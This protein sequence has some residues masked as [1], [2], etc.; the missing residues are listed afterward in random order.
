MRVE[1]AVLGSPSLTVLAVS[2]DVSQA[3]LYVSSELMSF[4]NR[5]VGLG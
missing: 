2:V 3:T 5:E 1:V 4:V